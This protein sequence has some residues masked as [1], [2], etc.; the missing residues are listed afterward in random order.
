MFL[1]ILTN[2]TGGLILLYGSVADDPARRI[3]FLQKFFREIDQWFIV[4]YRGISR[5]AIIQ[6]EPCRT[7]LMQDMH[8]VVQF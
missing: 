2:T 8:I 1:W 5:K 7:S 3:K 6:G 4:V